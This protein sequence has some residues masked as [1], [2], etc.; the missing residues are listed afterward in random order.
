MTVARVLVWLIKWIAVPFLTTRVWGLNPLS[1]SVTTA[2]CSLAA[3]FP[4]VFVGKTGVVALF[5]C[6]D[7]LPEI[8]IAIVRTIIKRTRLIKITR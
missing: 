1:V 5:C 8:L 7:F 6:V 2:L 3:A 4:C